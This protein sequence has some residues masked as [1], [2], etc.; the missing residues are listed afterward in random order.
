MNDYGQRP[1]DELAQRIHPVFHWNDLVVHRS[2][3][4]HLKAFRNTIAHEFTVY[5]RW[6]L[7]D[8][9]P[10]GRGVVALFSGP[11]G[12]GK[13][14]AAETI[15]HDLGMNLY[16]IDLAG[17][18]S[19]YIG[20][21][22]KNIKKIFDS[23]RGTNTLLFFDEA[24]ALFGR[25]TEIHDSHDR[26][27]NL[28]VNYLLQKLEEHDG[29]VILATNRRKNMDE[30]F[31]RR[32]HFIIEFTLPSEPLRQLIWQKYLPP[33][34]P[35]AGDVDVAF[36]A[37]HFEVSGG[38]IKNAALQ[39]AFL[40]AEDGQAVSMPHLLAALRREYL[41]LGK[42]FPGSQVQHLGGSGTEAPGTRRRRKEVSRGGT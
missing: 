40:A 11:S 16:R 27:A 23:A 26:Y 12:T 37:K 35:R 15:A 39:A 9:V 29:P 4:E 24:D 32:I 33:T 30:A 28:E 17:V 31:L 8:K 22:E 10:R 18:V 1:L 20:E 42:V 14:M 19:K 6:R 2:L 36:L 21:T 5:E 34:L 41:K 38:D 7:G 3:A 25:R 13:T